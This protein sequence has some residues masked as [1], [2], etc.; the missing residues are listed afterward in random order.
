MPQ[1]TLNSKKIKK[2]LIIEDEGDV[3]LLLN[4]ILK[5]DEIDLEHVNTLAKARTYLENEAPSLILL[6]NKLPDGLG[7]DF[8]EYLRKNYPA[9]KIMMI[10]GY[11][12][13]S[14]KDVALHNGADLYLEKPFTREQVYQ[15]VQE[16]LN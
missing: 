2:V 10:S 13:A 9:V 16:L 5:K 3:C 11:F 8:I 1:T 12:P 6:D 4:I 15:S 7:M 14:T